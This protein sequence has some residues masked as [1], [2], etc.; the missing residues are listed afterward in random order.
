LVKGTIILVARRREIIKLTSEERQEKRQAILAAL[1]KASEDGDVFINSPGPASKNPQDYYTLS[2]DEIEALVN[3]NMA[4]I[5]A[6][7]SNMDK[8]HASRLL[9][10]LI[11]EKW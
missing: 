2:R 8:N 9:H 3:G 11:K 7:V 6:W 1:A 10:W 4:K 5:E